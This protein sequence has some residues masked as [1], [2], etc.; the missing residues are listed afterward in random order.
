MLEQRLEVRE[1][2]IGLSMLREEFARPLKI[3]MAAVSLVL[4]MACANVANLLLARGAA[5]RR[6]VALR[7]SLGATRWRLIRQTLT[8]SLLLAA[9][10]AALGILLGVWGTR[11]LIHFLPEQAGDPVS[12]LPDGAVLVFTLAVC[13]ISALLFGLVPALRSTAVLPSPGL[14]S[15]T[16]GASGTPLLRR[17]LVVAQVAFSTVLVVMASLFG[18][19]L[20]ELRSVDLGFSHQNVITFNLD[21][22]RDRRGRDVLEPYKRLAAQ[23]DVLAGIRSVSYGFPG[24]FQM[25]SSS[26]SIRVPGSERTAVEPADVAVAQVAPRY[27]ET[28]GAAVVRGRE[29]NANDIA[30]LRDIAVVNEAFVRTFLHGEPHPEERY[31]SFDK[32]RTSIVGVVRD[33]R[34]D[35][36]QKA[37]KPTIYVPAGSDINRGGPTMLVRTALPP[38]ALLRTVYRETL[39]LGPSIVVQNFAKLAQHVDESIFEQ[40]LLAAVSGVF[41]A[42]ALVLAAVGLYGVVAYGTAGRTAEIGVRIAMGARRG[43]VVWM[44]LRGS[45]GLVSMGL[46][47][48]LIAAGMAAKAVASI[49]FGILPSDPVAFGFTA[50]ALAITGLAAAFVPARR[51]ASIDPLRALRHE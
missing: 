12:A 10:G 23:L 50:A 24:P 26:A 6:E 28:I 33:V 2:G 1:A 17:A 14:R 44:I 41:G 32:K 48:G 46:A 11:V 19:S 15:E 5:R 9:S 51:A 16:G 27:F 39:K 8:E 49:L 40:R 45:L 21:L 3:L 36:I 25:G 42:L 34:Q 4:L 37:P 31:L 29:F 20:F 13:I 35:G 43:Q 30:E 22:P 47:I 7:F 38:M 18:H